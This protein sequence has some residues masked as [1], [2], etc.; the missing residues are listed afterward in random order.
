[1]KNSLNQ[2]VYRVKDD[3]IPDV[4]PNTHLVWFDPKTNKAHKKKVKR[5]LFIFPAPILEPY[6]VYLNSRVKFEFFDWDLLDEEDEHQSFKVRLSCRLECSLENAEKLVVAVGKAGNV[7]EALKRAIREGVDEF[8]DT[9]DEVESLIGDFF[10]MRSKWQEAIAETVKAQLAV[11]ARVWLD[12]GANE[13]DVINYKSSPVLVH[14]QGCSDNLHIVIHCVLDVDPDSRNFAIRYLSKQSEIETKIV[15]VVRTHITNVTIDEFCNDIERVRLNI[16]EKLNDKVRRFGRK[17]TNLK[18]VP[19]LPWTL[20]DLVKVIPFTHQC[21]VQQWPEK[22]EVNHQIMLKMI[23]VE[24]YLRLLDKFD[25][26]AQWLEESLKNRTLPLFFENSYVSIATKFKNENG[27]TGE[28]ENILKTK[29]KEEAQI[30][31]LEV[32]QYTAI[33]GV[34]A[35]KI[36][37]EGFR[38]HVRN[39]EFGTRN[40]RTKVKL[41]VVCSGRVKNLDKIRHYLKPG[42]DLERETMA[43]EAR[44]AIAYKLHEMNPQ[45][46]YLEFES[47]FMGDNEQSVENELKDAVENRLIEKFYVEGCQIVIKQVDTELTKRLR[48]LINEEQSFEVGVIP[49][50]GGERLTYHSTYKIAAV[51]PDSWKTFMNTDR[52]STK[53]ELKDITNL[54]KEKVTEKLNGQLPSE[55]V[56]VAS[57]DHREALQKYVYDGIN[58]SGGVKDLIIQAYGLQIEVLIFRRASTKVEVKRGTLPEQEFEDE[59][60]I[61]DELKSEREDLIKYKAALAGPEDPE[62]PVVEQKLEELNGKIRDKYKSL[63]NAPVNKDSDRLAIAQ[64]DSAFQAF[65]QLA[66]RPQRALRNSE[67]DTKEQ[68]PLNET[69]T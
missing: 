1:M 42:V 21:Q 49:P 37:K 4:K 54:I 61:L 50:D 65:K 33:L 41:D 64:N 58:G 32:Q 15:S 29:M 8:I 2:L 16:V 56:E 25:S 51:D 26:L 23:S 28:L 68:G 22:I 52:S 7:Q 45:R 47:P 13:L 43:D 66:Q 5:R 69:Q 48:A 9:H 39:N 44:S 62:L 24:K 27:E 20:P 46:F 35:I 67:R 57:A 30:Y 34:Q 38:F 17:L 11:K 14:A 63:K 36:L 55:F 3:K 12:V 19:Q 59:M 6:L 40:T 60:G 53:E 31:G 18:L 10:K